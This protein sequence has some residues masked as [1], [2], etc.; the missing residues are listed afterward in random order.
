[1][2]LQINNT[3]LS[4]L[5]VK[6]GFPSDKIVLSDEYYAIPTFKSI[7]KFGERLFNFLVDN[8]LNQW[9]EETFD[10]D[11]FAFAAKTLSSIDNSIFQ[12][13]TGNFDASL[14]F[15]IAFIVTNEGGGHAINIAI[16][17]ENDKFTVKYF[18]PQ[19]ITTKTNKRLC[20][21]EL[22]KESFSKAYWCY[23]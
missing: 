15:G 8:G 10:C 16:I 17:K 13:K 23:F 14:A 6:E 7:E 22:K 20:L 21:T 5:L 19:I 3:N 18:E 12:S 1:M 9:K 4:E 11:D 2:T